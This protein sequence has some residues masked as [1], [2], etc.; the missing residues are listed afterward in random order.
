M[1]E[2]DYSI[3]SSDL[4]AYGYTLIGTVDVYFAEPSHAEMVKRTID[5][6]RGKQK[7]IRAKAEAEV[8]D[9][10][11]QISDLL[12]LEHKPGAK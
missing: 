6:L 7:E 2:Y 11:G 12:C 9:I 8:T 3:F 5:M 10:E 4:S 1:K